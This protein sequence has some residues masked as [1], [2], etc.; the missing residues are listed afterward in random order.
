MFARRLTKCYESVKSASVASE[1]KEPKKVKGNKMFAWR[2]TQCEESPAWRQRGKIHGK[3][4]ANRDIYAANYA[5][6]GER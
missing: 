5:V 1:R 3:F 6:C 2:L 4:K